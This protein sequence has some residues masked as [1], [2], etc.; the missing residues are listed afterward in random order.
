MSSVIA[1]GV[2]LIGM[3]GL[4]FT[5]GILV[6]MLLS[7]PA[8]LSSNSQA[9]IQQQRKM[10]NQRFNHE[11][12]PTEDMSE[13][14]GGGSVEDSWVDMADEDASSYTFEIEPIGLAGKRRLSI[15]RRPDHMTRGRTLRRSRRRPS[16]RTVARIHDA[17][18]A[19]NG[20]GHDLEIDRQEC[21]VTWRSMEWSR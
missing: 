17:R 16:V 13:E 10:Y 2:S 7:F 3:L 12:R 19:Y 11:M 20:A 1:V 4:V 14:M 8:M 18:R 21:S 9:Y 15:S 5:L 6:Q